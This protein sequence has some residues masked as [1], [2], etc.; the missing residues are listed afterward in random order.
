MSETGGLC[1]SEERRCAGEGGTD[2]EPCQHAHD[3]TLGWPARGT[4]YR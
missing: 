2:V 1:I 3:A 4:Q